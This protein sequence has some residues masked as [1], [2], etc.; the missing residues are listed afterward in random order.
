MNNITGWYYLHVNGSLIY[1]RELD[2]TAADIRESDFARHLWPFDAGSREGAWNICVEGLAFGADKARVADLAAQWKCDDE[3]AAIYAE[4]VGCDIKM[5][6]NQWCATGPGFTNLQESPAGFG[7]TALEA[8]AE[9]A[10]AI[11]LAP[12]KMWGHTFQSKLAAMRQAL[13][14][15]KGAV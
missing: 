6:G 13:A 2:G 11:G 10:K 4:W 14:Q 12:A 15:I 9:L 3:D 5:D 1:K 7:D 8:M